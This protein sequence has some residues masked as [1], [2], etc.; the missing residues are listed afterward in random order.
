MKHSSRDLAV[1]HE[2][3]DSQGW[4]VLR[5]VVQRTDVEQLNRVFDQLMGTPETQAGSGIQ[6]RP[7]SSPGNPILLRHLYDGL[8][9]LVCELLRSSSVQL[10]QDTLLLKPPATNER[11]ALHQDYSYTGFLDPPTMVSVGLAL[12][13]ASVEDGCLY[14]IDGSHRWGLAGDFH[15]FARH[16]QSQVDGSLSP[17]Q[18]ELVSKSKV[19]LEVRAGD[20]TIHHCLTF[21]G[22]DENKSAWPRKAIVAHLLSGDCRLVRDRLPAHTAAHFPTDAN[23]HLAADAFPILHRIT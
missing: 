16:L 20:V 8:A 1:L 9:E 3:F 19:P 21:H 22:S 6:Q 17:Q 4:L 13:D 12:S 14:V 23:G 10:L 2:S 11:I 7:N 5:N 15:I 18:R